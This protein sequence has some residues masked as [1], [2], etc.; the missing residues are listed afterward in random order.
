M[1]STALFH[2]LDQVDST[3]NYAMGKVHAGLAKHGMAW[4]AWFQTSGKGQRGRSWLSEPGE[5]IMLSVALE[6]PAL[7]NFH[8]FLFNALIAN[9]CR[10]WLNR[11][12]SGEIKIKWPNDLYIND[13]KAGGILIENNYQGK[14]WKWGVAGIG[15]N[16]NQVTFP[17]EAG[18]PIS[19][20]QLTGSSFDTIELARELHLSLLEAF[21]LV[22]PS[23]LT[24]ILKDYN[25]HLYK[26]GELVR[27]RKQN[28]VFETIVKEADANGRLH[29]EDNMT[30][31]FDFGEVEWV[32]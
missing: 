22:K 11:Y 26:K 19:L 5:N 15:I 32:I 1:K 31:Q 4:F 13:R 24:V 18:R 30:R 17:P 14:S 9:T 20:K 28:I 7:F 27:L 2:I 8:P 23:D 3:N 16:I 12:F 21:S 10:Q 25:A 29:T 6:P